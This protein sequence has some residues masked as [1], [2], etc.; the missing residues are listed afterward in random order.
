MITSE[1]LKAY[2]R[3]MSSGQI[4]QGAEAPVVRMAQQYSYGYGLVAHATLRNEHDKVPPLLPALSDYEQKSRGTDVIVALQKTPGG[5]DYRNEVNFQILNEN[6]TPL[7]APLLHCEWPRSVNPQAVITTAMNGLALT[8]LLD[9]VVREKFVK[10]KGTEA[11]YAGDQT[12][13]DRLT[14]AMQEL[15]AAIVVLDVLRR[16]VRQGA[17]CTVVPAP[18]QFER[19]KSG[20]NA[21]LLVINMDEGRALGVQIKTNVHRKTLEKYDK[22]R[23]ILID[24]T[25]DLN[26]TRVVRTT[27]GR[28]TEAVKP[29]PGITAASRVHAIKM[30]G[31][32]RKYIPRRY[33]S[34]I[35]SV[36]LMAREAVGSLRTDHREL[37]NAISERILH[38]L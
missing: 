4:H 6:M 16:M 26:N 28:S 33:A 30:H 24:G 12:Y 20:A 38:K 18:M 3:E 25:I 10:Q 21:D 7:W 29:W 5:W 22:E 17:N 1:F 13:L 11:L 36:K 19:S 14:G 37:T 32:Q 35:Q 23:V 9:F 31:E 34:N 8:G 2:P 27:R 15:D